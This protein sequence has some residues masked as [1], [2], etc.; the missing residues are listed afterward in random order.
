MSKPAL[1]NTKEISPKGKIARAKLRTAALEVME[2]EKSWQTITQTGN[3]ISSQWQ[4]LADKFELDI[5][6]WGL[7]AL[8]GFTF[9]LPNALSYKTLITQEML[10]KGYLA[11]NSVYACIEH[12]QEIVSGYFKL[13]VM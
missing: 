2:R 4:S 3:N 6:T 9:N 1:E 11:A 13:D 10:K 8:S 7:P 5:S 12:K